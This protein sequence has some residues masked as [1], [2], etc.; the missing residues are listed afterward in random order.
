MNTIELAK[1]LE[2]NERLF[3]DLY[4]ECARLFPNHSGEF[5]SLAREEDHHSQ[6][7]Q[8]IITAIEISPDKWKIGKVSVQTVEVLQ[9]QIEET[10]LE[11]RSAKVAPRYAITVL[12]SYEQGLSERKLDR[13]LLTD[14]SD[15][16]ESIEI[17]CKGF[18]QHLKRLQDLEIKIFPLDRK[19]EK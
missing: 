16:K 12:R 10:L 17:I 14:D 3:G 5:L 7:F 18:D 1:L 9:K 13:L 19:N 11:I 6:L 15:F 8:K 4:R 2:K